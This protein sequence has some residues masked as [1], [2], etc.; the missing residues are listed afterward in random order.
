MKSYKKKDTLV[1]VPESDLRGDIVED[2]R[3]YFEKKLKSKEN[4]NKVVLNAKGIDSID[5]SGLQLIVG[6][7]K[8]TASKSIPFKINNAG[9]KLMMVSSI[10]GFQSLFTIEK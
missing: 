7:Y 10:F 2:Q 4:I 5:A 3:E 1:L 8:E 6:L 9:E